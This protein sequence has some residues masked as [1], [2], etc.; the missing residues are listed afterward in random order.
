MFAPSQ[1]DVRRFV[2]RV[3]PLR[4]PGVRVGNAGRLID[5]DLLCHRQ[6]HRQVQERIGPAALGAELLGKRAFRILQQRVILRV[7]VDPPQRGGFERRQQLAGP[8][9]GPGRA[10]KATYIVATRIE[11]GSGQK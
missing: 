6:V 11:H 4:Q 2:R 7:Y 10:E 1:H 3:E 8:M 5:T 9:F